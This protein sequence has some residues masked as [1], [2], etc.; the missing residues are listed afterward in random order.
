M[1]ALDLL[2]QSL[3]GGQMT[4]LAR[5]VGADKGATQRAVA[6]A[7]PA[8]LGQMRQNASS[9]QGAEALL[10]ALQRDHDG[11]LLSNLGALL[12]GATGAPASSSRA[13]NG[14]GIL[15]H[16]LGGRRG[17][18]E[19]GVAQASGLTPQQV[20]RLLVLLAPLVMA[21][22]GRAQRQ[23]GGGAGTLAEM[24]GQ[25][26]Q[27]AQRAAP[28]GLLGALSGFLDRD[29]DGNPVNDLMQG[30]GALGKLF[31]R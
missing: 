8:L 5:A 18:L 9:P 24:L 26:A 29:G 6:A 7:L 20:T 12:G 10:G 30:G 28:G 1:S 21:A 2:A 11:S 22:L 15:E 14:A 4:Q 13:A 31:G 16:I 19:Q 17:Q 25:E 27:T 3:G 23:R